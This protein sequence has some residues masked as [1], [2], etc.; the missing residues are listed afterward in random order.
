[1]LQVDFIMIYII[2]ITSVLLEITK[3]LKFFLRSIIHFFLKIYLFSQ[4][5]MKKSSRLEE[6]KNIEEKII[7]AVRNQLRLEKEISDAAI[8][9]IS[10]LFKENKAIEDRIFRDIWNLF[11]HEDYYKPVRAGNFWSNDYIEY[12]VKGDRKTLSVEEYLNKIRSYLKD[13]INNLKKS[14]TWK[15]QLTI[16]IDLFLLKMIMM[17]SMKCIQK[18]IR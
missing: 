18:V 9:V 7:K 14:D 10:N 15:I 1:M 11:E 12:K 8:K 2:H 4:H 13:I 17:K 16:T 3:I 5:I 6:D